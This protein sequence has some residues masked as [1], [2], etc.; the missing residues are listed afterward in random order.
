VGLYPE[1][2]EE[3][4]AMHWTQAIIAIALAIYLGSFLITAAAAR[5]TAGESFLGHADGHLVGALVSLLA[6]A[7][8]LLTAGAYILDVQ[9]LAVF[10]HIALLSHPIIR[11][12]G[13]LALLLATVLLIWAEV[14][15]GGSFR[16]AL[17]STEQPLVTDGIYGII[18]NPMALS[19]D[20]FA[21]GVLFIAPSYLALASLVLNAVSYEWKVRAEE[22]YLRE[23]HGAQYEA[24]RARTGKYLPRLL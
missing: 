8:L 7:M 23:T 10:G 13:A 12:L 20:L 1:L 2:R 11:L 5:R 18:R 16:I 3:Y 22:D 17:P 6:S 14:S 9:S 4:V 21:L 15:I 19:V 24:Y